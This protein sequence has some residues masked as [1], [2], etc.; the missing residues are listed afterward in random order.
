MKTYFR[1]K[2][3]DKIELSNWNFDGSSTNQGLT[4]LVL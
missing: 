1:S 4:K 3:I 2:S